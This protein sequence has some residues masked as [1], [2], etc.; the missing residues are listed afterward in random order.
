MR[1]LLFIVMSFFSFS[2]VFAQTDE[3]KK[4]INKIKKST[5]YIYAESTAPTE[6]DARKY[7][8]EK[9]YDAVNE[10]VENKKRKSE[11]P[12]LIINNKKEL[13]TT[14]SMPRGSN[15]YRAFVYVKKSDVVPTE[16]AVV[17][18][19]KAAPVVSKKVDLEIPD[20]IKTLAQCT[21]FDVLAKQALKMQK[22]GEIKVCARYD[23][24]PNRDAS[25]LVIFDDEGTIR[26]ILTPGLERC[27][28]RTGEKE[29]LTKY[30]GCGVIG[31]EL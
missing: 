9:L 6:T 18:E 30:R 23:K 22:E 11:A 17:I 21:G 16:N 4:E 14:L 3:V 10:W 24:L 8:E 28:I 19:N 31:I 26:A 27:N 25:Y 7:A 1:L 5:R 2:Q 12:S 20:A 13:W 29:P 15:M